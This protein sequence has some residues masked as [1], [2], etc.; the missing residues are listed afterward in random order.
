MTVRCSRTAGQFIPLLSNPL[1]DSSKSL[2]C[3]EEYLE[4]IGW[5][6]ESNYE[7][8][9]VPACH[10]CGL[11]AGFTEEEI[12]EEINEHGKVVSG[13]LVP[14]ISRSP[15]VLTWLEQD[16][17]Y[18]FFFTGPDKKKRGWRIVDEFP[19]RIR[20]S[21][22][23]EIK[24]FKNWFLDHG[25]LPGEYL[26]DY[27]VDFFLTNYRLINGVFHSFTENNS[28]TL[29][30]NAL[31]MIPFFD[32]KY[33][34]VGGMK[35]QNKQ[36]ELIYRDKPL[37]V[38]VTQGRENTGKKSIGDLLK[39]VFKTKGWTKLETTSEKSLRRSGNSSHVEILSVKQDS[40]NEERQVFIFQ[41]RLAGI[42]RKMKS[43]QPEVFNRV[44]SYVK[45]QARCPQKD[46]P[47]RLKIK[48]VR[49]SHVKIAC[50]FCAKGI[51][52][53][54][55]FNGAMV[56]QLLENKYKKVKK[57]EM[58]ILL[59][60]SKEL[61]MKYGMMDKNYIKLQSNWVS[62]MVYVPLCPGCKSDL[63]KGEHQEAGQP[64]VK[65]DFIEHPWKAST[66]IL[67]EFQLAPLNYEKFAMEY[68]R[69][70]LDK[71]GIKFWGEKL[72]KKEKITDLVIKGN[73]WEDYYSWLN[74]HPGRWA[75]RDL[76]LMKGEKLM[77]VTK[78][79]SL[80][81]NYR[82]IAVED[83]RAYIFP[84]M[85]YGHAET[86]GKN[87]SMLDLWGSEVSVKA[88]WGPAELVESIFE[89]R[90][91]LKKLSTEQLKELV[92][93][94]Q[95]AFVTHSVKS[96]VPGLIPFL[97]LS[98]IRKKLAEVNPQDKR[99]SNYW[100]SEAKEIIENIRSEVETW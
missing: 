70:E 79:G 15:N 48:K 22:S 55:I 19:M 80:V 31:I 46:I 66:N 72:S 5:Y 14:D 44:M 32:I 58:P 1:V 61:I 37:K 49:E 65:Q 41:T 33:R 6:L 21:A 96:I 42:W 77:Y 13:Q 67:H 10:E 88:D 63:V 8:D 47:R 89:K 68:F 28:N 81:T 91:W 76:K 35:G 12:V 23:Q 18:C 62:D 16:K 64:F 85:D 53:G 34:A 71:E 7:S 26:V 40:K 45:E 59:Q 25:I 27:G 36:W 2:F 100:K 43:D 97:N 92:D 57:G 82:V 83:N 38:N 54:E 17:D 11:E 87:H 51:D 69:D 52:K 78:K 56:A 94:S 90:E 30:I 39:E 50:S 9:T 3:V 99:D 73:I 24:W 60:D 95:L 20:F 74:N 86:K 4:E 98:F 93:S 84:F 29:S 75:R